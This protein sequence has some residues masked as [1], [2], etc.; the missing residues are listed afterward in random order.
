MISAAAGLL[1]IGC[2]KKNDVYY[3]KVHC[4]KVHWT[5]CDCLVA[6]KCWHTLARQQQQHK[7]GNWQAGGRGKGVLG[8]TSGLTFMPALNLKCGASQVQLAAISINLEIGTNIT[9]LQPWTSWQIEAVYCCTY[10]RGPWCTLRFRSDSG[11]ARLAGQVINKLQRWPDILTRWHRRHRRHS[12][13][14][15]GQSSGSCDG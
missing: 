9:S 1:S 15:W 12:R 13:L 11:W 5:S 6:T 4:R 2:C 3:G 10:L 7:A 8:H 14:F